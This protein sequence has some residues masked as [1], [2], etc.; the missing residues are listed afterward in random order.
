MTLKVLVCDDRK[1]FL[2]T[3][4][5]DLGRIGQLELDPVEPTDLA[6]TLAV[7]SARQKAQR[8]EEERDGEE[9]APTAPSSEHGRRLDDADLVILDNDLVHKL[10]FTESE[11]VAYLFRAY[12]RAGPI[13]I[14]NAEKYR[15]DLTMADSLWVDSWAELNISDQAL[16]QPSVWDPGQA[17]DDPDFHPWH[18]IPLRPL[19]RRFQEML[20]HVSRFD[21]DATVAEVLELGNAHLEKLTRDMESVVGG[22][23]DKVTLGELIEASLE[24]RDKQTDPNLRARVAVSRLHSWLNRHVLPTQ[25]LFMDAPHLVSRMPSLLE[26]DRDEVGAWNR[27]AAKVR[28]PDSLGLKHEVVESARYP[29]SFWFPMPVWT[30]PELASLT[31]IEEVENPFFVD[32][33]P[34]VFCEDTSRYAKRSDARSI[35]TDLPGLQA[36]RWVRAKDPE[37]YQP[38]GRLFL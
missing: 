7:L 23:P 10:P 19:V 14:I 18:W 11:Q 24:P 26:G 30:T 5:N 36:R 17:P 37:K 25:E 27:L 32:P 1:R 38:S 9:D 8:P 2:E 3:L 20:D 21:E 29:L 33:A 34:F 16:I 28:D 35:V 12:S 15:F 6:D 4:V 13:V 31:D 22:P